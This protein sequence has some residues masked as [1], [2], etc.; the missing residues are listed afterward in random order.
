VKV[1]PEIW[2]GTVRDSQKLSSFLK[3]PAMQT[4]QKLGEE[5]LRV[6]EFSV[7]KMKQFLVITGRQ[8]ISRKSEYP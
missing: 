6:I 3:K 5:A 4:E 1:A 2:L 7:F 8:F